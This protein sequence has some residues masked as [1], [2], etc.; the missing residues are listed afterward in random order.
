ML[1]CVGEDYSDSLRL[2]AAVFSVP[3]IIMVVILIFVR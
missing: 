1:H 2:L 3:T